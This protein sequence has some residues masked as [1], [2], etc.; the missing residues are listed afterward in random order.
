MDARIGPRLRA[1][2]V[3][4]GMTQK[5]LALLAGISQQHLSFLEKG[6]GGV[7][8]ATLQKLLDAL[9][10]ELSFV[11]RPPTPAAALAGRARQWAAVAEWEAS[12]ERL[13]G[14]SLAQ[15][16]AL[17]DFFLSRHAARP[18]QA[19]LR[20]QAKRIGAW[21]GLLARVRIPR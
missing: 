11:P 8:L 1:L 21:R 14:A 12:R 10:H 7:E 20:A 6:R 9:G 2:R 19:D 16:G 5:G 17:A 15:A 13:G 18:A 3:A 4:H